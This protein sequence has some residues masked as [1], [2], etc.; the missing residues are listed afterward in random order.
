MRMNI[1]STIVGVLA[2]VIILF[3]Y[4]GPWGQDPVTWYYVAYPGKYNFIIENATRCKSPSPFLVLMVP[5]APRERAARDAIRQTWGGQNLALGRRVVT[6]FVL[7][8]PSGGNRAE[9]HEELVKEDQQHHDLIQSDFLDSYHNL[10]IKTMMMLEWFNSNCLNASYVMKIDSDVFLS[11]PNLVKLLLDPRIAQQDYMTG[12]VWWESPV[13]RNIFNKFYVPRN[14]IEK[15]KFPPYPLG[16]AYVMSS[17]LPGKILGVAPLIRTFFIEDVYLGMCLERLG[18]G[19][20]NPLESD[21]FIV[22]PPRPPLSSCR[23]SKVIAVM[24]DDIGQMDTYWQMSQQ[25]DTKC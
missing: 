10:T 23:L 16:M 2:A 19:P 14:V 9:Q 4:V 13:S 11:V 25:R 3:Y 6:F 21:T 8:L 17:D 15:S 22:D 20:T 24:T 18:I 12:L 7:G 1:K 5:V